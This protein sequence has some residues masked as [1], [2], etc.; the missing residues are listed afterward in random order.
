MFQLINI[1]GYFK[2]QRKRSDT[3]GELDPNVHANFLAATAL[4][5][6]VASASPLHGNSK[7]AEEATELCLIVGLMLPLLCVG[8]CLTL[9]NDYR[10]LLLSL[11]QSAGDI[12]S[13]A[14]PI[15]EY[16]R[17]RVFAS[18]EDRSIVPSNVDKLYFSAAIDLSYTHIVIGIPPIDNVRY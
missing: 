16:Y 8:L 15:N 7:P 11:A 17:S 6:N 10:F 18:P 1:K 2:V 4:L 9:T 12:T 14:N 13:T 3:F 5:T